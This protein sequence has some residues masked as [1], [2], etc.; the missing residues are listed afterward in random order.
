ML[1]HLTHSISAYRL[2]SSYLHT[3]CRSLLLDLLSRHK[4]KLLH[5]LFC[6]LPFLLWSYLVDIVLPVKGTRIYKKTTLQFKNCKLEKK[7]FFVIKGVGSGMEYATLVRGN[8]TTA[9]Q[10]PMLVGSCVPQTLGLYTGETQPHLQASI[11]TCELQSL[12]LL[13]TASNIEAHS[14]LSSFSLQ[15]IQKSKANKNCDSQ[16]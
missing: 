16:I 14:L 11:Y 4:V 9:G 8:E 10:Q 5:L 6:C 15:D 13:F 7:H 2:V 12:F 3:F 1:N